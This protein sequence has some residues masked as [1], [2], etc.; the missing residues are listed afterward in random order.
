MKDR[1]KFILWEKVELL[2]INIWFMLHPRESEDLKNYFTPE[3]KAALLEWIHA[4]MENSSSNDCHHN[5]LN[6]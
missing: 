3:R 1:W 6:L 5:N 2:R 4:N